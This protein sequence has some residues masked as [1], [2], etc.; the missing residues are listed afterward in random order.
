[1]SKD[2]ITV[3]SHVARDF[4]QNAAYFG[5]TPKVV[6]EYVSN[7]LDNADEGKPIE[8]VVELSPDLLKISDNAAGMSRNE[9]KNFFTMHGENIQRSRGKRV[10][11]RFGTG[12]C[13][14]FGIANVFRVDTVKNKKRNVLEL[15]RHEIEL[16]KSGEPFPVRDIFMDEPTDAESGTAIEIRDFNIKKI[17]V[18]SAITYVERHLARYR[19]RAR[20][21]I[22]NHECEFREPISTEEFTF[23]PTASIAAMI[24]QVT[25]TV[26]I[27]PAPLDSEM[28]GID[29]LSHGIWHDTTLADHKSKEQTEYIFGEVDVPILEDKEWKIPPFDNTRNNT[30]NIQN[31]VVAVLMGWLSECIDEVRK[32]LVAREKTRRQSE[33]ARRLEKE[34]AK[35]AAL[36][37]EDFR[38]LQIDFERARKVVSRSGL[39]GAAD[40]FAET[41]E[42]LPGDG[43]DP[44]NL[45]TTG[46]PHGKGRRGQN[47]P[48]SGDE[49]RNGPGLT[50]GTQAGSKKE[51]A[52]NSERKSRRGIFNIEY[53]NGTVENPRSSYH[54]DSK[55]IRINL[56]HP[57]VASALHASASSTESR[58]FRE[59]TY[60]IACVEYAL[61]VAHEQAESARKYNLKRD[62]EDAL[63]D[64]RDSINRVSRLLVSA[65]G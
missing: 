5:T 54:P 44:T 61:A 11:G 7:S 31:P 19:Q 16:A 57:Q 15:S 47:P 18:E 52:Q 59:I 64:V 50:D 27:S 56:D 3:Q 42:P 8:V 46:Q 49:P 40:M 39:V 53:Y 45:Q 10:R 60:E 28:N 38:K 9:L 21:W 30:L 29:V 55:T 65:L 12:K 26:K 32:K 1:M 41:G 24:G 4:L 17:D 23:S 58:Q 48:G 25:L 13:A 22:N 43:N 62:A 34:A 2:R 51:S 14:A 37:N 6:W 36:L 35:I 33:Q 20:V 63:Y